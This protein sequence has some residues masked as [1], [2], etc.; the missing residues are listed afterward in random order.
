M[1]YVQRKLF[2]TL[3][4]YDLKFQTFDVAT[5]MP[6]AVAAADVTQLLTV[7]FIESQTFFTNIPVLHVNC[8]VNASPLIVENSVFTG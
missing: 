6:K 7:V 5:Y 3:T 2:N 4:M 8:N 1:L